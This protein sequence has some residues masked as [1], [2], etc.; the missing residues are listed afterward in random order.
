MKPWKSK[1]TDRSKCCQ[2][3][4]LFKFMRLGV[5]NVHDVKKKKKNPSLIN[6]SVLFL[7]YLVDHMLTELYLQNWV[8]GLQGLHSFWSNG[9]T[10]YVH[11]KVVAGYVNSIL[12]L[13]KKYQKCDAKLWAYCSTCILYIYLN[14]SYV[15]SFLCWFHQM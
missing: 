6:K 13:Q 1:M 4:F 10:W 15:D 11:L 14:Q 8:P 12:Y 2:H 7:D 5:L 3:W 9:S